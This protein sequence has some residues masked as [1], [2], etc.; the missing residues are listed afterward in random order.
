MYVLSNFFIWDGGGR[1]WVW[2]AL[3]V[4]M[5]WLWS[6]WRGKGRG[7]GWFGDVLFVLMSWWRNWV[8]VYG[9]GL[10]GWGLVG[11]ALFAPVCV[12]CSYIIYGL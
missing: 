10:G 2:N 8:Q 9:L 4:P 1:G 11:N 3:S 12:G 7:W 5:C 6:S